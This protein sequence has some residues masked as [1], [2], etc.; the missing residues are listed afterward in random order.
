[1]FHLSRAERLVEN[2]RKEGVEYVL[3][4][5]DLR[6]EKAS[7]ASANSGKPD[8]NTEADDSN[9]SADDPAEDSPAH[10]GIRTAS[11]PK[12][13]GNLDHA[14]NSLGDQGTDNADDPGLSGR[15]YAQCGAGPSTDPPSGPPTIRV[16]NGKP[17]AWVHA[18][19][20]HRFWN[21]DH[22]Q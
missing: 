13:N 4:K 18:G 11:A 7:A 9:G 21:K 17:E 16:K 12:R 6:D 14:I 3:R 5:T 19:D 1:M 10:R 8:A 15:V 22:L 20:C 2:K